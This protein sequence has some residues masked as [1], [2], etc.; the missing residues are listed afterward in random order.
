LAQPG[1]GQALRKRFLPGARE[2]D[3]VFTCIRHGTP[4]TNNEAERSLRPLVIFRKVC[5]GTRSP[6]GSQ[7]IAVFSSL[8]ETARRQ[9]AD[10]IELLKQL[11][12]G[13]PADVHRAMFPNQD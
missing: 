10:S 5:M 4:P 9:G 6:T 7:N 13:N 1:L 3:E 12:V 8:T 2:R 11:F